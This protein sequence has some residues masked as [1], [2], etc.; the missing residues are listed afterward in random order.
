MGS[1]L[2]LLLTKHVLCDYFLQQ[3]TGY[4]YK[5]VYGHA[6]GME[7]AMMHTL[8]T[9]LVL[10]IAHIHPATATLL[11]VVDGLTHYHLDWVKS[12]L[13]RGKIRWQRYTLNV[14]D[15]FLHV[16]TYVAIAFLVY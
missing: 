13:V 5:H 15:Q 2:C 6:D 16:L 14:V 4:K 3:A 11:A 8:G 7:H 1:L 12:N 10:I 9:F